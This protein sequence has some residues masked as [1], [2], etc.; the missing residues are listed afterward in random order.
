MR[1]LLIMFAIMITLAASVCYADEIYLNN[2]RRVY[3]TSCQKRQKQ[4]PQYE[5]AKCATLDENGD[6]SLEDGRYLIQEN[7]DKIIPFMI[8]GGCLFEY[9]GDAELQD[10]RTVEFYDTNGYEY[11]IGNR[12]YL[13]S[14]EN[15][16]PV[17]NALMQLKSGKTFSVIHSFIRDAEGYGG[18]FYDGD[19]VYPDPN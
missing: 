17:D 1:Q 14:G 2:G 3:V 18:T 10:G 4:Y 8:E 5:C 7:E 16:T 6:S 15:N 19:I 9:V 13:K 11:W 12:V